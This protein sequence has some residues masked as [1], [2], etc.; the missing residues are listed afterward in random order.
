[1]N[2]LLY[3]VDGVARDEYV[4]DVG[5]LEFDPR[6]RIGIEIRPHHRI[7]Q[8]AAGRDQKVRQVSAFRRVISIAGF[9]YHLIYSGCSVAWVSASSTSAVVITPAS[10]PSSTTGSAPIFRSR[11][12]RAASPI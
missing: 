4:R 9:I 12:R 11:S 7:N 10:L 3:F 2:R 6:R 1:M 5:L 8:R